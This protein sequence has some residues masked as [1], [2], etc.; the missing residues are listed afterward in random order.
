[1][2]VANS[3]LTG[4]ESTRR[5]SAIDDVGEGAVEL[6]RNR[7]IGAILLAKSVE[8]KAIGRSVVV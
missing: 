5:H 4:I 1:M 3:Q 8:R 2:T 6:G 7:G